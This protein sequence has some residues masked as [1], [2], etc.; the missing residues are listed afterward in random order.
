MLS[1]LST[2]KI[3]V[4]NE[5]ALTVV[6]TARKF[7]INMEERAPRSSVQPSKKH[8]WGERKKKM[9]EGRGL[10]EPH[11]FKKNSLYRSQLNIAPPRALR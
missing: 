3:I 8:V 9:G 2:V 10:R 6:F 5:L 1:P 11:G 4:L 7:A